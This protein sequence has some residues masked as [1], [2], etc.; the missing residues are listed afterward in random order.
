[1]DFAQPWYQFL[2]FANDTCQK[3]RYHTVC[4][5]IAADGWTT[6]AADGLHIDGAEGPDISAVEIQHAD[7]AK[8]RHINETG[9]E[10]SAVEGHDVNAAE[11]RHSGG[12]GRDIEIYPAFFA[13]IPDGDSGESTSFC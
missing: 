1:M 8:E 11:E 9:Q 10:I 13:T 7:V 4:S 12:T 3:F 5:G 2:Y 6:D